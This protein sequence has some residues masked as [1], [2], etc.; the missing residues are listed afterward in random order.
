MYRIIK[1]RLSNI[2]TK[3]NVD[4]SR[5]LKDCQKLTNVNL[6]NSYFN[7]YEMNELFSGCGSLSNIDLSVFNTKNVTNMTNIFS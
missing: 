3:N 4:M 5:I 2:Q 7:A 6:S 1:Y